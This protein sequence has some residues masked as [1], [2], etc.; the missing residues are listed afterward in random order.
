MSNRRQR[1]EGGLF[2]RHDHPSCPPVGDDG[3]R[4]E[5]TSCRG[6]WVGRIDLG[7]VDGKQKRRT[8]YARTQ[9]EGVR[10]LREARKQVEG[11][12]RN[13]RGSSLEAWLE[14]WLREVCPSKPRMKPKTLRN[15]E[16]YVETKIVPAIGKKR[17]DRLTRD[18]VRYLHRY[19]TGRK[20]DGLELSSTTARHAHRILHTALHDALL[21]G[22]I[23]S[24]VASLV[25]APPQAASVKGSLTLPQFAA[26]MRHLDGDR[27]QS[28]WAF[29]LFT[30]ARQGECLGLT[31]A[32][33]DLDNGVADLAWQLQRIPYRHDCGAQK[34]DKTWPCGFKRPDRCP[35]RELRVSPGFE[36]QHLD[37]NLCLQRP[38]TKGSTRVIPLPAMLLTALR[39]RRALYDAER[40]HYTRD[41]GLVWAR[42]DGRPIDGRKDWA[43]WSGHLEAVGIPHQALHIGRH[44]ASTIMLFL[45]VPENIRM[46]IL[47]HSEAATNRLYSHVDLTM[48]REAMEMFGGALTLELDAGT[49]D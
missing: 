17:L 25:P 8:I 32:C 12:N 31:W 11:G 22:K 21:D 47:G 49:E 30:G 15:Y 44:T 14:T 18:D 24:N 42:E 46:S 29:A 27:L 16:S 7:M 5:H 43:E 38:K 23:I 2:Q 36:Y 4:P 35:D 45:K 19:V 1:G 26:L 20:P 13:T 40:K 9:A 39:E 34:K 41:H 33:L 10:K 28:R 3:E 6:T 37:G 48:Q